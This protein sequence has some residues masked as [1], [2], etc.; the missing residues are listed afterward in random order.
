MLLDHCRYPSRQ[1]INNMNKKAYAVY[2]M[3]EFGIWSG[4]VSLF[5]DL[6]LL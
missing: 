3:L 6:L 1:H 5:K 2:L 4:I